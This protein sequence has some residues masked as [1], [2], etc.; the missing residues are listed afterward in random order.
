MTHD[1][2][3]HLAHR[4]LA[5]G[6][7]W[8]LG[9]ALAFMLPA[10][11]PEADETAEGNYDTEEELAE[12]GEIEDYGD[13]E[14]PAAMADGADTV[15]GGVTEMADGQDTIGDRTGAGEGTRLTLRE[16]QTYGEYVA[17]A[18]GSPVYLFT[19]DQKGQA[20]TCYDA[21]A[22]AWPPVTGDARVGEG[23]DTSM[24]GTITRDDGT[25]QVTYNGWPLYEFARD[26]GGEPS[27]QDIQSFGGEWYLIGPDGTEVHAEEGSGT[28]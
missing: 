16:S 19:A 8:I 20:S 1:R 23:L 26:S 3:K 10:C 6:R 12:T 2:Q 21:C 27:G 5:G 17:L 15:A 4:W 18:D 13:P 24:L 28:S 22:D 25:T 14:R 11:A 9:L 7:T